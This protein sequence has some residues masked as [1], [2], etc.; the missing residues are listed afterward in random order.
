MLKI[1]VFGAASDQIPPIYLTAGEALGEQIGKR[2]HTLV[3]G[4]GAHG[5]MGAVARGVYRSGGQIIGI[6]PRFF[7]APGVF[8]EHCT[9]F[10]Y[11][12]TMR[13]RKHK[14]ESGSDAFIVMPG[15]NGTFE[16]FLEVFTLKKLNR[17]DK[18]I[19]VYDI[20]HYYD[21]LNRLISRAIEEQFMLPSDRDLF[22]S[23][24]DPEQILEQI[25]PV[26]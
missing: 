7:D 26:I 16:E 9:E 17:L 1:C 14:M 21:D 10:V 12:Q 4:G 2:G 23:C 6:A 22:F 24:S 13:Q 25:E 18:P 3:F 20:N 11:T 8:F 15:G 5:L 19:A